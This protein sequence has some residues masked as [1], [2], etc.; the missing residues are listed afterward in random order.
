MMGSGSLEARY[1]R[2][3]CA[4]TTLARSSVGSAPDEPVT[5]R[6]TKSA[7]TTAPPT[8]FP[9][10]LMTRPPLLAESIACEAVT[11]TSV[12]CS[13]TQSVSSLTHNCSGLTALIES[14][15][16]IAMRY[17][18]GTALDLGDPRAAQIERVARGSG[19]GACAHNQAIVAAPATRPPIERQSR[20][21]EGQ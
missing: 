15:A 11:P 3:A 17:V 14:N 21:G 6:R 1:T 20:M 18:C 9:V 2:P 12:H 13:S 16:L 7:A 5:R 10:S 4:Q 19:T 8:G